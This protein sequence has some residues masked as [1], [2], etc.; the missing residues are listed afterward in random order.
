M[1]LGI[2]SLYRDIYDKIFVNGSE[3]DQ[4][5]ARLTFRWILGAM[6]PVCPDLLLGWL[7]LQ[8][9]I[10]DLATED[11]LSICR[12][13]LTIEK[14]VIVFTHLTAKDF[15]LSESDFTLE[16]CQKSVTLQALRHLTLTL[17]SSA[18]QLDDS[19]V[20]EEVEKDI[21]E[22]GISFEQALDLEVP[23]RTPNFYALFFWIGQVQFAGGDQ[24]DEIYQGLNEI[25]GR[26]SHP[27]LLFG[28]LIRFYATS[29][30]IGLFGLNRWGRQLSYNKLYLREDFCR[31]ISSDDYTPLE[32]AIAASFSRCTQWILDNEPPNATFIYETQLLKHSA[33]FFG[34]DD[35]K[36]FKKLLSLAD[37][38][39]LSIY[40]LYPI[41]E[42]FSKAD[43]IDPAVYTLD[44][45]RIKATQLKLDQDVLYAALLCLAI[46]H[47]VSEAFLLSILAQKPNFQIQKAEALKGSYYNPLY[48]LYTWD[49]QDPARLNTVRLLLDHG[50]NINTILTREYFGGSSYDELSVSTLEAFVVLNGYP[51]GW[52]LFFQVLADH[53]VK[54]SKTV[55]EASESIRGNDPCREDTD[56]CQKATRKLHTRRATIPSEAQ[57]FDSAENKEEY[58][59]L[60]LLL[61]RY[62]IKLG[63]FFPNNS[64]VPGRQASFIPRYAPEGKSDE[65]EFEEVLSTVK[66]AIKCGADINNAAIM[67]AAHLDWLGKPEVLQEIR[68]A[69]SDADAFIKTTMS[70]CR[71][72]VIRK[73]A[74]DIK[75]L[76]KYI[77]YNGV[78]LG[79]SP[80]GEF[81]DSLIG[82]LLNG[83]DEL[84]EQKISKAALLICKWGTGTSRTAMSFKGLEHL[85]D[86]LTNADN[87]PLKEYFLRRGIIWSSNSQAVW[88]PIRIPWPHSFTKQLRYR[89]PFKKAIERNLEPGSLAPIDPKLLRFVMSRADWMQQDFD[90]MI[91]ALD[92]EE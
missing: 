37:P 64:D 15:I 2:S 68:Q 90:S 44:Y 35:S 74:A 22:L 79:A 4:N 53:G 46:Q 61:R 89:D 58:N 88:E 70:A 47:E 82:I 81:E 10:D 42:I 86:Y 40:E 66:I 92:A 65:L 59:F 63:K 87:Q 60:E 17:K 27:S 12:N 78:D 38:G 80:T 9:Q 8:Y 13:I 24:D 83:E 30:D 34:S 25:L 52:P 67:R 29:H 28:K 62:I 57:K 14:D 39:T 5:V 54:F 84:S 23:P 31:S 20:K 3:L 48:F 77:L 55:A 85:L 41:F 56:L 45:L 19:V 71:K 91:A 6:T 43:A 7:R 18:P 69:R 33:T 76:S 26:Q 16:I 11:I 72:A 32:I 49:M 21:Q 75:M 73:E 36:C 50:Y 51:R 1:P